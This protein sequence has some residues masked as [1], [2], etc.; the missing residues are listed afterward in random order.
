M[1]TGEIII[2]IM[3]GLSFIV[4]MILYYLELKKGG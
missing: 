2:C 1:D 3:F 4:T